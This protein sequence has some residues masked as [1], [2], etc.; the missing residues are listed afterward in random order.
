MTYDFFLESLSLETPP[1]SLA[2]LAQALWY[3]KRDNW[4]RAHDI[5][6]S[7]DSQDAAWVHAYLH[8]VEGDIWNA[9]YW[10]RRAGKT[11]P[12]HTLDEEWEV[13]S[14]TLLNNLNL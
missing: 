2:P 3:I 9:D 6:Q 1:E 7:Y 10:Y 14:K 8:R 13:I 11:R 5:A 4:D 12:A